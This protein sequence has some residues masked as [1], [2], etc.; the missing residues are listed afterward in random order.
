[1]DMEYRQWNSNWL[2]KSAVT[3]EN[4]VSV[5]CC[6]P[7]YIPNYCPWVSRDTS[8]CKATYYGLD[9]PRIESR[10][11]SRFSALVHTGPVSHPVSYTMGTWSFLEIELT[12]HGVDHPTHLEP[13]LKKK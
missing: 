6:R 1:M 12:G 9:G 13:R 7:P 5:T 10:W 2:D 8:V 11:G 3:G 4:R